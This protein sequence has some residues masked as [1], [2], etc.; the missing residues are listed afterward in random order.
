MIYITGDCH[1]SF[2][3][4]TKKSRSRQSFKLCE[5]DYVIICGD[6]GLCWADDKE[7]RYNCDWLSRLP[8]TIL[9]VQGNHENYEMIAKYPV[10]QWCGGM[11]RHIIQNKIILLERGQIFTI[12][13][14]TFFSMGGASSHDIQGGILDI[15]DPSYNEL[16][17]HAKKRNLPYRVI[18]QSYWFEELPSS[19]ELDTGLESLKKVDYKVDYVIS[20]CI[21][22]T[23]QNRLSLYCKEYNIR[24]GELTSDIL[25][26]YFD[27]LEEKLQYNKWYCGHYHINL[28]IDEKH[29]ILYKSIVPLDYT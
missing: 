7:F 18:G 15:N 1:G 14:K 5:N 3:R 28:D 4:F 11:V 10:E 6:F 25:T 27:K 17:K 24:I 16:K 12:E 29:T 2:E 26:D 22:N 19:E 20:H 8:F 9:W 13:N 21:S 23:V